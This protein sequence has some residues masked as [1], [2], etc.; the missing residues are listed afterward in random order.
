MPED[1]SQQEV[2]AIVADYFAMLEEELRGEKYNKAKHNLLL[3][4]ILSNRSH[5]SVEKK[6]QNISAVLWHLDYPYINGYKPL[7]RYQGLLRTVVE[8]WLTTATVINELVAKRVRARVEASPLIQN[9]KAIQVP[10][11]SRKDVKTLVREETRRKTKFVKRNYLEAEA[12]NHSLGHAGEKLILHIEHTRLWNAGK[13]RLADKVEHIAQTKDYLGYD[14]LS[15]ESNGRE[16]LI[17]VKTTRFGQWTRFFASTNEVEIS[18]TNKDIFHLYRLFNFDK[19]PKF[20]V[21]AGSL[22]N[23]CQLK[24]ANYWA[25][26]N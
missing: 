24:P 14:I 17:E 12:N 26:P 13:R 22:Q 11:P 3:R 21:L 20:F 25:V 23:T 5:G 9:L 15:F 18:E 10:P 6:H 2:E 8:E 7:P 1:W 16:R 4:K 19:Q